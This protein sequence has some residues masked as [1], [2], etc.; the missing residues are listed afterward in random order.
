MRKGL[1][2]YA[3]LVDGLQR[4]AGSEPLWVRD[5]TV[6]NSTWGNRLLQLFGPRDGVHA[7]GGGI[8]QG[9]QQA[10]GA[11]LAA[12]ARKTL[13]ITGDGGLQVNLGELATLVQERANVVVI[14]MNDGGYGVIR[15]IQD[16][17]YGSRRVYTELH[18][19]DFELFARSLKLSYRKVSKASDMAATLKAATVGRTDRIRCRAGGRLAMDILTVRLRRAAMAKIRGNCG[20]EKTFLSIL[21]TVRGHDSEMIVDRD[22]LAVD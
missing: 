16:A 7:L 22:D 15:N 14:V 17:I 13:C 10:L 12:P 5:V 4:I 8:G 18:N 11:A 2:P 19:P 1:A 6:S 20:V 9:I 3:P 21:W